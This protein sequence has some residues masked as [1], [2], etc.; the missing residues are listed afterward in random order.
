LGATKDPSAF[1]TDRQFAG[2][3]PVSSPVAA[4]VG[5]QTAPVL[6][7]G[8]TAPGLYLVRIGIPADLK[9]GPQPIEVST[10]DSS[11]DGARTSSL[12]SLTIASPTV[13]LVRNGEFESSLAGSWDFHA[14]GAATAEIRTA[15]RSSAAIIVR[16]AGNGESVRL[17]QNSLVLEPRQIYRLSFWAKADAVRTMHLA[18][19][20]AIFETEILITETWQPYVVY[21]QTSAQA[22]AARLDVDFGGRPGAVWLDD[23]VLQGSAP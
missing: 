15:G 20:E 18:I 17:S 6:F 8:L 19:G 3:F 16:P 9:P 4:R 21:F 5:G 22:G 23:I 12:L 10:G 11:T 7:A 14:S 1:V 13:N 2:A